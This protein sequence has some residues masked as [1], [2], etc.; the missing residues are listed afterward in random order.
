[1]KK[2]GVLVAT[3]SAFSQSQD[4]HPYPIVEANCR[5]LWEQAEAPGRPA[6]VADTALPLITH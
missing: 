2:G 1:M 6:A 3:L 5:G 4:L